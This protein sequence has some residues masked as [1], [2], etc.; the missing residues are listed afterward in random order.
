LD[1]DD[2]TFIEPMK[3]DD[4]AV[5]FG[6]GDGAMRADIEAVTVVLVRDPDAALG[7]RTISAHPDGSEG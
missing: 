3:I 2:D 6:R 4:D 1:G 5:G 7:S